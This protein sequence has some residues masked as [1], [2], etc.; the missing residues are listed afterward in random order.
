M[1]SALGAISGLPIAQIAR[2]VLQDG[3][4]NSALR[5]S[6]K[7]G[8]E[9]V[10]QYSESDILTVFPGLEFGQREVPQQPIQLRSDSQ[11]FVDVLKQHSSVRRVTLDTSA[12]NHSHL[13][14]SSF[15]QPDMMRISILC[16]AV[17]T[18]THLT[19]DNSNGSVLCMYGSEL[20]SLVNLTDFTAIN[21]VIHG[22]LLLGPELKHMTISHCKHQLPDDPADQ[23]LNLSSAKRLKSVSLHD[24]QVGTILHS[25]DNSAWALEAKDCHSL[26]WILLEGEG[27]SQ[28]KS[29]H[30]S[31]CNS[32]HDISGVL[33]CY[34]LDLALSEVSF[35][36]TKVDTSLCS[37]LW[38]TSCIA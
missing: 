23:V 37:K 8:R 1:L 32:L 13:S 19:L 10:K 38:G 9:M 16:D 35:A 26:E 6:G 4:N 2:L 14:E 25:A 17:P 15:Y 3:R 27:D 28:L 22:D 30:I 36:K 20:A 12:G 18:L 5:L 7:S 31:R 11:T 29:V 34:L 33:G 24:Y 21:I